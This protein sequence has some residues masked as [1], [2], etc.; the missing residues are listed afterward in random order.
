MAGHQHVLLRMDHVAAM[1]TDKRVSTKSQPL[2]LVTSHAPHYKNY[3]TYTVCIAS[4]PLTLITS[5]RKLLFL[6]TSIVAHNDFLYHVLNQSNHMYYYVRWPSRS[7]R[8]A[9]LLIHIHICPGT[10]MYQS[11]NRY[12]I[13]YNDRYAALEIYSAFIDSKCMHIFGI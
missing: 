11:N 5:Y 1:D 12:E 6:M 4:Q 9:R 10:L 3:T 8:D 2:T 13:N 7:L